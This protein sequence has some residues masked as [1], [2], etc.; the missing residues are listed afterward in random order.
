ML[1]LRSFFVTTCLVTLGALPS[2]TATAQ[3]SSANSTAATPIVA[4]A[5]ITPATTDIYPGQKV[6]FTA[7]AKD[8]SGKIIKTASLN[9]FAVPFDLA[10][11]D[12]SGTVSFF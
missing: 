2:A 10:A 7:V 6:K 1:S 3:Q 8:A 4:T 12:E 9:W 11:V 5:V